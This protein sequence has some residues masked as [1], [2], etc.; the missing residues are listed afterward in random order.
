MNTSID[1]VTDFTKITSYGVMATPALVGCGKVVSYSK[2]L[3]TEEI[4]DLL[5]KLI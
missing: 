4:V 5:K 3:K 2:V 1:H